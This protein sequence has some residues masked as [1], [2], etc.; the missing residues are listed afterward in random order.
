MGEARCQWHKTKVRPQASAGA[1]TGST[2]SLS[3][4]GGRIGKV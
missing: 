4:E 3:R 2:P 1:G